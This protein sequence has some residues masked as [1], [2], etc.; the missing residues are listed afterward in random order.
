MPLFMDKKKDIMNENVQEQAGIRDYLLGIPVDEAQMR[1]IEEKILLDDK[2][3]DIVSIAEDKLIED[4]LDGSLKRDEHEKFVDFFLSTPQRRQQFR[5]TKNFRRYSANAPKP[6][7]DHLWSRIASVFVSVFSSPSAVAA[8]AAVLVIVSFL[9]WIVFSY[10]S[11]TQ[12]VTQMLDHAYKNERPLESRIS[13]LAY[14]PYNVT[15]GGKAPL[16][17]QRELDAAERISAP[18]AAGGDTAASLQNAGRVYL[19]KENFD[20]AIVQ[21]EKARD[22]APANAEIYSDL[23]A[24]LLEKS[25][26]LE[27]NDN[28]KSLELKS[29]ALE[30]LS[31]AVELAPGLLAARFNKAL[32]LQRLKMN[33]EA[34]NAWEEYIKLDPSSR[35]TKE[36]ERNLEL[37]S[38][39][40]QSRSAEEILQDFLAAR[41]RRDDN[42]AYQIVSD[43]REMIS[44]KL[45]PQQ[46]AFLFLTKPETER[47]TYLS[48]LKYLGQI[49]KERSGDTYVSEIAQYYEG[50]TPEKEE[51][52]RQ[53]YRSLNE[54]YDR[55]LNGDWQAIDDFNEAQ[56]KFDQAGDTWEAR[57]CDY[58]R[59]YVLFKLD[60]IGEST[61]VVTQLAEIAQAKDHK[62]LTAQAFSWLAINSVSLED[63][64]KALDHNRKA[65]IFAEEV[66]DLYLI[67]KVSAQTAD[68]YQRLGDF[69]RAAVYLSK[70][71]EAASQPDASKRQRSRDYDAAANMF[72]AMKN[73]HTALAYKRASIEAAT[74]TNEDSFFFTAY[75]GIASIYGNQ[76]NY[77]EAYNAFD[78]SLEIAAG[79]R[80][81]SLRQ[82]TLAYCKLQLAHIQRQEG[83]CG[84]A[85][86]N[87]GE[88][89][90]YFDNNEFQAFSYDAHKGKLLCYYQNKDE[91]A[92]QAELPA[93]FFLFNGYRKKITEEQ[94]R[95]IFFNNEQ[96]VYDIVIAH[97]FDRGN[98]VDAFDHSEESR[99]RT[100]LDL[101]NSSI[102]ASK[103]V[104][105]EEIEL[106]SETV[107]PLKLQEIQARMPARTQI[108][109]YAVLADKTLIW[110][111]T[112]DDLTVV[113]ADITDSELY[114]IV[115][116]YLG[117]IRNNDPSNIEKRKETAKKL[118]E[119]L[120][121]PIEG[122]LDAG[123]EICLIPDKI[124]FRLP[125][126]TLI[127]PANGNYFLANYQSFVSPSANI[128]LI[129]SDKAGELGRS[130]D[131]QLLSIGNPDFDKE[132]FKELSSLDDLSDAER[133][134]NDIARLYPHNVPLTGKGASKSA[135]EKELGG[136]SVIHF[137]GHYLVNEAQPALSGL[138]LAKDDQSSELKDSLLANHEIMQG[139]LLSARLVVL[140]ACQ[141]GV[142]RFYNGEGM[143]GSSRAF[144]AMG[145]PLVVAS[146]WK[147]DSYATAELM[148]RFH[149]YR[150]L[151]GSSTVDALRRAQLDML[152]MPN[153]LYSDPYYWA[154][155]ET[156]GGYAEF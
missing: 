138:V 22:L 62:W 105:D 21:F 95:N 61:Q 64:S 106:P 11:D 90:S 26:T 109:Q 42:T 69:T 1:L 39:E 107:K 43:N 101:Q 32:C 78:K 34:K 17:D 99:A 154:A 91:D 71:L 118:Y 88:A 2:F 46:L 36:A 114:D 3:A 47:Q 147:V 139:K 123:K 29:K 102:A 151:N 152:E 80:S 66:S 146:Q 120:I 44:R 48:A 10:R 50:L 40:R 68:V 28:G 49:E 130:T 86:K 145:V 94:S 25:K 104:S 8:G 58:W 100:L 149:R 155:F 56:M 132:A 142:E 127:S 92:F 137:A 51:I 111:I 33:P 70:A 37:L 19:V 103:K 122:K 45:I 125:F 97:E 72:F 18:S 126:S 60:R 131:E 134:V 7:K 16:T 35:W 121:T 143:A 116:D 133:E 115:S 14:A 30:T 93:I 75:T 81:E 9:G 136:A 53:A 83:N 110:L 119:L 117:S 74:I 6:E 135:V 27:K 141:S 24:A 12:L 144:L 156:I 55:C 23:G 52:L 82:K 84:A 79:L 87:Y 124:L 140:S 98:Y 96:S 129:C 85:L 57:L 31:K 108:V 153:A 128:F 15:R 13:N 59:G 76:G 65:L 41:E 73:Y 4:F 113:K 5:L 150:K 63:Y 77:K 38:S 67:E 54:G 89:A 112:K 20:Q 148:T